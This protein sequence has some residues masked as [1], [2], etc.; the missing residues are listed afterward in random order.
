M[1]SFARIGIGYLSLRIL[2]RQACKDVNWINTARDPK[3]ADVQ[4]CELDIR[5]SGS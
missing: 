5:G 2:N 3:W 4:G 1:G